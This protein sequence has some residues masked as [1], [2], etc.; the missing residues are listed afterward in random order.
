MSHQLLSNEASEPENHDVTVSLSGD[1]LSQR[2]RKIQNIVQTF[3]SKNDKVLSDGLLFV[4]N[5][6]KEIVKTI[7]RNLKELES[8]VSFVMVVGPAKSGKSSFVNYIVQ[9]DIAPTSFEECTMLPSIIRGVDG[10]SYIEQFFV[11][12]VPFSA[13]SY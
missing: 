10:E 8:T 12:P 6:V 7:S 3:L 5:D 9:Q 1:A 11:D 13:T 2:T 4:D